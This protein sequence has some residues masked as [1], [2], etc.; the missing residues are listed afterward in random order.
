MVKQV[1]L[2]FIKFR[3]S[4]RGVVANV[5]NIEIIVISISSRSIT[6]TFGLMPL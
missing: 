4:L 3:G 5:L 6:F 1:A 2:T